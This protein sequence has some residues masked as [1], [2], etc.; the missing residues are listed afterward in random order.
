MSLPKLQSPYF[1]I[2]LPGSKKKIK[3]RPFTVKEEK[4]LLMAAQDRDDSTFIMDTIYQVLKNCIQGEINPRTLPTFDV[5]KL[6]I[7]LRARSVGSK[8]TI[9]FKGDDE[10]V[11]EAEIDLDAI[12]VFTP[13]GH[14][15]KIVLDDTYTITMKYPTFDDFISE[16]K[17]QDTIRLIANSLDKLINV[18]TGEIFD[19]K[20][21]SEDE[22]RE[23][24]ESFT[25]KNMR[26][27]EHFFATLPS[28]KVEVQYIT[29]SGETKTK[30][31]VGLVNFF[32]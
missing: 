28:V 1:P 26:D 17:K 11:H 13:K 27:V 19:M 24:V 16:E 3:I 6:F 30:E 23:F 9:K 18:E 31:I 12:D 10:K 29:D 5:E 14:T 25:S 22:V 15:N 4:L 8:T 2:E 20:D 32:S 21:H 7:Q